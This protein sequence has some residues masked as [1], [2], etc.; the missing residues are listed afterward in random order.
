VKKRS[1]NRKPFTRELGRRVLIACE[2]LVTERK[3]FEA[4]RR[5]LRLSRVEIFVVPH[6][7]SDPYSVVLAAIDAKREQEREGIWP[8]GSS[9]WAVFDGDE[10]IENNLQNWN[11]ALQQAAQKNINLAIS[12]PSFEFWYLI[13]F[14]D[15][16]ANLTRVD[17]LKFLKDHIPDYTKAKVL[18]PEPLA[19]RTQDA[20]QRA[21]KLQNQSL[22]EHSNPCCHKVAELVEILLKLQKS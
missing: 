21:K 14:Q 3:Y 7:G 17:A 18:Y 4:I 22:E 6:N 20:I 19:S 10:H 5:D 15:Y 11:T 13:H 16:S 12:N 1:F 2:G 8:K 9:A